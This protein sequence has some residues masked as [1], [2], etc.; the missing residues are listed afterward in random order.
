MNGNESVL[1]EMHRKARVRCR[2]WT[3]VDDFLEFARLAGAGEIGSLHQVTPR[4]L[5]PDSMFL[6]LAEG[7]KFSTTISK[8][9][10]ALFILNWAV[11]VQRLKFWLKN[12]PDSYRVVQRA[13]LQSVQ[14]REAADENQ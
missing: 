4:K 2:E 9:D 8:I 13:I 7:V 1:R 5:T 14:E 3:N 12:N 6:R 11:S 10:E